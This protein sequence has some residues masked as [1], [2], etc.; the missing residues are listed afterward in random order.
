MTHIYNP[1][2]IILGGGIMVQPLIKEMINEKKNRFI[3]PSFAHVNLIPASL[4]NSAGLLGANFLA[5]EYK[6]SLK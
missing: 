1:S 5:S 4:G 3:M 6:E 2:C